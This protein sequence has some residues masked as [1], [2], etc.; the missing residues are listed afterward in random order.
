[1]TNITARESTLHSDNTSTCMSVEILRQ[2]VL[3]DCQKLEFGEIVAALLQLK[4]MLNNICAFVQSNN[5]KL[6]KFMPGN[7]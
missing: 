6:V 4:T 1:M 2:L 3:E 7:L 5:K